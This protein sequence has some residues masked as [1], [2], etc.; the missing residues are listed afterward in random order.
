MADIGQ[1]SAASKSRLPRWAVPA[2]L[3]FLIAAVAIYSAPFFTARLT[4][5]VREVYTYNLDTTVI[6]HIVR[7]ALDARY[8]RSD[9][10]DYGQLYFNL[11]ILQS[12]F[13]SLFGDSSG[14]VIYLILRLTSF[15]GGA[16]TILT[17]FAFA[18]HFLGRGLGLFSAATIAL[19]PAL[20]MF[21]FE[22]HPDS[23]QAFF[24]TLSLYAAA[25][26]V[27][28]DGG[29]LDMRWFTAAAAAAGAAFSSKYAGVLLLP[30]LIGLALVAP[31]GTI[32]D[33]MLRWLL[34]VLALTG[35]FMAPIFLYVAHVLNHDHALAVLPLWSQLPPAIYSAS[36]LMLRSLLVGAALAGLALA[37]AHG[38][39]VDFLPWRRLIQRL[40]VIVSVPA[41]F[42]VIFALT[43]PWALYRLRFYASAYSM[44]ALV[45]YGLGVKA[46]W[47][48]WH[49]ISLLAGGWVVGPVTVA[50]VGL[51]VAAVVIHWKRQRWRLHPLLLPAIW[52]LFYI[53]FM[54]V[55]INHVQ[56]YYLLP[57]LPAVAVMAGVGVSALS[58]WLAPRLGARTGVAAAV[59][60]ALCLIAQ[61]AFTVPVLLSHWNPPNR[62]DPAKTAM[63]GW[64]MRCVPHQSR[65]MT[66]AYSYVP[67]DFPNAQLNTNQG[68]YGLL[69]AYHPDIVVLDRADIKFYE[70]SLANSSTNVTGN[71]DDTLRYFQ[72]VAHSPEWRAG[73]SFGTYTVFVPAAG[74]VVKAGCGV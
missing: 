32:R 18:R 51:G 60:A 71:T 14:G 65:I 41:V 9:F 28:Q 55:R 34:K 10:T 2:A 66:A 21:C 48:G 67:L 5:N 35:A 26:A 27:P 36:I 6:L 40:L 43:S 16:L 25:R 37:L 56:Y 42:L 31:L 20:V 59:I 61:A 4:H 64:L 33:A 72:A 24:I 7:D 63:A 30:L 49:W 68:G 73:P 38:A 46:K 17:V 22:P 1:D 23:W 57:G 13:Y 12:W 53:S 47:Y 45:N 3:G 29:V 62:M 11:A 70:G 74:S 15:V 19:S 8:F 58:G 69:V 39:G 54:M 52:V 44:S 50:L